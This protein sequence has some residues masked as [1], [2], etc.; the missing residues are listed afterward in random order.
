MVL[1]SVYRSSQHVI[2]LCRSICTPLYGCTCTWQFHMLTTF[3]YAF[4][5]FIHHQGMQF[6]FFFFF[7][8]FFCCFFF[9]IGPLILKSGQK[10]WNISAP[11][12]RLNRN[13]KLSV[14]VLE[15]VI[16][17]ISKI[18]VL[19]SAYCNSPIA[20]VQSNW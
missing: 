19:S 7:F 10:V 2:I 9:G 12:G 1:P 18:I 16:I 3:V 8:F 13:Q 17:V 14:F 20:D 11:D 5:S 15:I 4:V 6:V